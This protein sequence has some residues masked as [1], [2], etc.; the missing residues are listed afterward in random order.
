MESPTRFIFMLIIAFMVVLAESREVHLNRLCDDQHLLP[1][2]FDR[3]DYG[4][5]GKAISQYQLDPGKASWNLKICHRPTFQLAFGRFHSWL[6]VL[7]RVWTF[8]LPLWLLTRLSSRVT[9]LPF[10][11]VTSSFMESRRWW[12]G[13]DQFWQSHDQSWGVTTVFSF[14]ISFSRS[15][16]WVPIVHR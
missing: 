8:P 16:L 12:L 5:E 15:I 10:I 14:W 13:E 6:D 11:F 7:T 3:N 4:Q 1:Q 9:A 2:D